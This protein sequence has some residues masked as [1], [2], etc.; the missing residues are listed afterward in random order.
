MQTDL[1]QAYRAAAAAAMASADA[2]DVIKGQRYDEIAQQV[3]PVI[4]FVGSSLGSLSL[5]FRVPHREQNSMG[6]LIK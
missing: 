6:T 1:G 5:H 2:T 4:Y 3:S